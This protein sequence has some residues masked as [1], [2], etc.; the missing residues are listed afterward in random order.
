MNK[1]AKEMFE[2]L[3]YLC[4]SDDEAICFCN[5]EFGRISFYLYEEEYTFFS[6]ETRIMIDSKLRKAI[7]KQ[8]EELGWLDD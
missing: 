7:N 2:E 5:K 3:G 6:D 1:S 4:Y 8:V